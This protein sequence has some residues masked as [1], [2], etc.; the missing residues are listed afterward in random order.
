MLTEGQAAASRLVT[1]RRGAT[2][3]LVQYWDPEQHAELAA[4]LT[5][6]TRL[7]RYL[8]EGPAPVSAGAGAADTA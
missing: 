1:A 3:D 4:T 2:S 7:T 8:A 5:R 6:L